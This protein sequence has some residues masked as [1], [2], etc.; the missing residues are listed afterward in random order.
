MLNYSKIFGWAAVLLLCFSLHLRVSAQQDRCSIKGRVLDP[1]QNPIAY[2]SVAIYRAETPVAGVV[3][4]GKGEFTLKTAQSAGECRL[5]V[6]FIGY[7]KCERVIKPNLPHINIG[8]IELREEAVAVGEVVVKGREA[9]QRSTVEHTTINAS[10]NMVSGKGTALDIL[11]GAS[12]VN[13]SNDEV[14]IRGNKNILV[15]MDGVPTT[16]S[17]LAT[18]PS[19]NIQ[20]IEVITNPDASHD[21]GGT[22]GIIN[23]ISKRSR[24]EGF[25]GMVAANYGFNHFANGNIALAYNRKKA[26]WRF[27]YNTKYED[28]MVRSTLR[29][30]V[31]STGYEVFQ[32]MHSSR[33]TFNTNLSLGADLRL[34]P[35]NRLSV[36]VKLLIPRL[37]IE[38]ELHNTFAERVEERHN[39]VTWNRENVEGSV[40]YTHIF[41]PE[42]SEI[43]LRGSVSKIWGH[44]PSYYSLGGEMVN[45][46]NSGGSPFISSLQADYKH[47]FRA[48][49]LS[50]G[51]KL[52][53]RS[54][55]IYHEFYELSA[56]G[57]AYSEAMSNDLLHTELVP[58]A[59]AM[60]ASRIGK[61]FSYKAGLRG[62]FSTVTLDSYREAIAERNNSFFLAPTLSGA[63]KISDSQELSL[64]LS[65]R[66]GRPTYPQLNPYMSMVDATTFEQG[67]MH[68][69]AEK[70]TKL[71]VS[72]NVAGKSVSLFVN[73]YIGYTIDYISQLTKMAGE[74]LITTYANAERDLKTGVEFSFK[75]TP[76]KWVNL[77]VGANTYYVAT[78]G[79]FEGSN[80]DNDGWTNNSNLMLDFTP[81]KGGAIQL[82]YFLTTPQYYPQL[83]TSLTHQMNI[84]FKQRLLKGAMTAS[85]LLT[86]V[87]NTAR[88]EVWS[89]N[90]LFD[91]KNSSRNKSR[92]LWLGVSYNFNSFK[93]K[94][95]QKSENDRSL[96]KLGM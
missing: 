96:I 63:Y 84:G 40:G 79:V 52:T 35:S 13:I 32:Q 80:I 10:A 89:H 43:T 37:N 45:R 83:T 55:D 66:V 36:D 16:V 21:A 54:N 51:A 87:L 95:T 85:V 9:A 90:N 91:L 88:W 47:K 69:K 29:R 65:R 2:A 7:E 39:D 70:A 15:L 31:H 22:G 58:A 77:S 48:G 5:V 50:A 30:K 42:V 18:I 44:R 6:E 38:Q 86:D 27:S 46:S 34:N 33:Y 28:D 72:Y 59:Y 4:D 3:T 14:A 93:S 74:R 41:K 53:Y 61:K 73:G 57:W 20:S 71:D 23:I 81:W 17:D 94:S 56:D 92:M 64:A 67:N 78:E 25:S 75:A 24:E 1:Q 76:A 49:T 12:S 62:E 82:Q 8:T 11:R 60:F 68:L 26:S 19:A